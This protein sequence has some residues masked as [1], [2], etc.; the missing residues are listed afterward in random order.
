MQ[1][2]PRRD[3]RAPTRPGTVPLRHP[4]STYQLSLPVLGAGCRC[5]GARAARARASTVVRGAPFSPAICASL[6]ARREA[7]VPD[8]AFREHEQ[9]LTLR[10]GFAVGRAG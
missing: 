10:I 6:I 5:T 3:R 4:V 2:A 7:R 8:R 9:V 1:R